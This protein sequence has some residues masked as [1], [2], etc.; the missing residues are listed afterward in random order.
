MPTKMFYKINTLLMSFCV[1]SLLTACTPNPIKAAKPKMAAEFLVTA[2]KIAQD[3]L[4]INGETGY[5]YG[6]CMNGKGEKDLCNKLYQAMVDYAK[7]IKA[8]N[9]LS[10]NN[11]TDPN[12]FAKLAEDYERER[13]IN[14]A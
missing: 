13:F 12:V 5:Y 11:L 6:E 1:F 2:S 3:K 10:V 8:F 4:K 9:T 7:T 14:V